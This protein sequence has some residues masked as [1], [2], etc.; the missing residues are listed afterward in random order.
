MPSEATITTTLATGVKEEAVIA[1][2]HN[3]E[4]YIKVTCPHL[5]DYKKISG[6]PAVGQ[7]C[8][9]EVTDKRPIG[10]TTFRLTLVNQ[11]KGID[12]TVD[13]KS[14]TGSIHIES[15]WSVTSGRI[16]ESIA[17]DS[18]AIMKRMIKGSVEKSHPE[19]HQSFVQAAQA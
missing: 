17:I 12:A 13:G 2:L 1:S 18:N 19:H 9:Y 8:V 3:H 16:E 7:S 11:P 4:V 5:I 6:E 14:P 15:K 10:Q